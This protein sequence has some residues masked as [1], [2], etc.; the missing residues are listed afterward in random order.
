[1]SPTRVLR[2]AWWDRERVLAAVFLAIVIVGAVSEF[3]LWIAIRND[4]HSLAKNQA[5]V[6]SAVAL[7]CDQ[8]YVTAAVVGQ[9]LTLLRSEEQTPVRKQT[10]VILNGYF[11][12]LN[13]HAQCV[14]AEIVRLK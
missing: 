5:A 1:M 10:I 11:R 9:T 3:T 7:L 12:Q 2:G 6:A 14:Q 8:S 4:R 13:A